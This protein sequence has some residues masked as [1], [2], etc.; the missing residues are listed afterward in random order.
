M[1]RV[2]TGWVLL[3]IAYLIFAP[4]L[5]VLAPLA[6]LL[7]VSR[8]ASLGEWGWLA[9]ALIGCAVWL[10]DLSGVAAQFVRASGVLLAGAVVCLA[11]VR[12]LRTALALAAVGT[13]AAALMALF[14][15]A[16]LGIGW[17]AVELAVAHDLWAFFG[18]QARAAAAMP[19]PM[20]AQGRQLFDQLADEARDLAMLFPAGLVLSG[21][22]GVALAWS[23]YH[24]IAREP[25]GVPPGRFATFTFSDHVIWVV[26]IGLALCLAPVPEALGAVGANLLLTAGVLYLIRGAAVLRAGAGSLPR[27]VAAALLLAAIFLLAFVLGGLLLLG[28]ADTWLHFRRRP[29]TPS[30]G[31]IHR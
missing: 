15:C 24:R 8:P 28:L 5:F 9:G 7:L 29:T 3:L 31:G 21:L 22:G 27:P 10:A 12:R 19:G 18:D 11:G 23:G 4:G 13:A 26:V 14:W 30:T 20:G 1:R 6:G 2:S 25:L 17:R 16:A